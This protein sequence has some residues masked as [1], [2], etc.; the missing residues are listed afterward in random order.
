MSTKYIQGVTVNVTAEFRT[1]NGVLVDP[2]DVILKYKT[3]TDI[4]ITRK[5]SL[6]EITKV[7]QGVYE[8]YVL[9]DLAGKYIFRWEGSGNSGSIDETIINVTASKVI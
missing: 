9:L 2:T 8:T 7:S 3:P 4:V 1:F 6:N 5:Y